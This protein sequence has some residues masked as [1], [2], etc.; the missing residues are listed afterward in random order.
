MIESV[1]GFIGA[2]A[3][4]DARA[5]EHLRR[6]REAAQERRNGEDGDSDHEDQP[7]AVGVGDLAPDQHQRRERQGVARHDP[8]ELG[9]IGVEVALDRRQRDVHDGVVEH[10]HEEPDRDR[11]ERQPLPILLCEDPGAH[12][13]RH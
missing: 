10:D 9:E 2:G 7:A 1:A 8:L 5:D 6:G 12:V 3:L 13:G 4:Q 11:R